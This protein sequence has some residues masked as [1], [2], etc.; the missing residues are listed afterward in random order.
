MKLAIQLYTLRDII[1]SIKQEAFM[2]VK[3]GMAFFRWR[4]FCLR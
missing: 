3:K 2:R 1:K 4:V